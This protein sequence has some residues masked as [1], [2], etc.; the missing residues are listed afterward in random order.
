MATDDTEL[1]TVELDRLR[2]ELARKSRQH[3]PST[4][5]TSL[6]AIV[7]EAINIEFPESASQ[8]GVDIP[9]GRPRL[10]IVR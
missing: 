10:T 8:N 6:L 7:V 1:V 2:Q 3:P 4:W 5:S 9:R